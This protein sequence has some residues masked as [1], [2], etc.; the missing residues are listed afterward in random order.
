[1][2]KRYKEIGCDVH[3]YPFKSLNW[4]L[5]SIYDTWGSIGCI[6][7]TIGIFRILR[8]CRRQNQW[9]VDLVRTHNIQIVHFH[10]TG[11]L[12]FIP[13]LK[14]LKAKVVWHI[15]ETLSDHLWALPQRF[16][17]DKIYR[18][19]NSIIAI[20]SNEANVFREK[21]KIHIIHNF[22]DFSQFSS[23][24]S[25]DAARQNLLE[26]IWEGNKRIV[27][28]MAQFN[29]DKG[30]QEFIEAALIIH[31][32][33]PESKFVLKISGLEKSFNKNRNVFSMI[34]KTNRLNRKIMKIILKRS[35]DSY[36]KLVTEP[37]DIPSYLRVL[38]IFVRPDSLGCPWGRDIIEAMA[39]GLPII[40]TGTCEEFVVNDIT[41][42][43]VPPKN[44]Q[45]MADAILQ[46]LDRS[47]K[48][49]RMGDA[50]YKRAREL[51]DAKRNVRTI[52]AIYD[53][54]LAD[55]H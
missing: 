27:G 48:R 4:F 44:P 47:E 14:R 33:F 28:M 8:N 45:R 21:D 18:H 25:L 17:A 10:S 2:A 29:Q 46:L 36:I 3:I 1:M 53:Q 32:E 16:I 6:Q 41:G 37:V 43:L 50:G 13:A 55:A 20:T 49:K 26:T 40:A 5:G 51:F 54:L 11:L 19:S 22:V 34:G 35:A 12:T 23:W 7:G 9:F 39:M 52:E 42:I 31:S 38:D 24:M 30:I 15:R